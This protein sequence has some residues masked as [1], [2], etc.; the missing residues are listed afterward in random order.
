MG[1]ITVDNL[2]QDFGRANIDLWADRNGKGSSTEI[3]ATISA[4]IEDVSGFIDEVLGGGPYVTPLS[5]ESFI[6]KQIVRALVA[7]RLYAQKG[8]LDEDD[9]LRY[10]T[11]EA[12]DTLR[13]IKTG[14]VTIPCVRRPEAYESPEILCG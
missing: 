10:R 4:T 13:A 11:K 8:L 7:A 3:A 6:L 14:E 2:Y 1:Y 5:G 12:N 9:K